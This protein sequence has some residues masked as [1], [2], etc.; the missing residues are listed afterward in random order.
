MMM[1][2]RKQIINKIRKRIKETWPNSI[3]F[4]IHGEMFQEIMPDLVCCVEGLFIG[5]EGKMVGKQADPRQAEVLARIREAGGEG[6]TTDSVEQTMVFIQRA[7]SRH[8]KSITEPSCS[9]EKP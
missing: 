2:E 3:S 5:I 9:F 6:W 4:K 7:L 1:N 8:R